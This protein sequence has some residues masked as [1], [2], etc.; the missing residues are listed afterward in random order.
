LRFLRP[1]GTTTCSTKPWENIA[2]AVQQIQIKPPRLPEEDSEEDDGVGPPRVYVLVAHSKRINTLLGKLWTGLRGGDVVRVTRNGTW[3]SLGKP[4]KYGKIP[5][6]STEHIQD[7]LP[8]GARLY[9]VTAKARGLYTGKDPPLDPTG[10]YADQKQAAKLIRDDLETVEGTVRLVYMASHLLRGHQAAVV[11]QDTLSGTGTF[12]NPSGWAALAKQLGVTY[13]LP[14]LHRQHDLE[15]LWKCLRAWRWSG[16]R[17]RVHCHV[18]AHNLQTMQNWFG[19]DVVSEGTIVCVEAGRYRFLGPTQATTQVTTQVDAILPEHN[20]VYL[21]AGLKKGDQRQHRMGRLRAGLR[22]RADILADYP[23]D[24]VDWRCHSVGG[25]NDWRSA[26]SGQKFNNGTIHVYFPIRESPVTSGTVHQQ[27]NVE[28]SPEEQEQVAKL[29][30][31]VSEV[32]ILRLCAKTKWDKLCEL[33]ELTT[34]KVAPNV[35]CCLVPTTVAWLER[36]FGP[37]DKGQA[38]IVR[39]RK[40]GWRWLQADSLPTQET[41]DVETE[42]DTGLPE[43]VRLYLV[44]TDMRPPAVSTEPNGVDWRRVDIHMWAGLRIRVD[45]T[46]ECAPGQ[47]QRVLASR[48]PPQWDYALGSESIAI[49]GEAPVVVGKSLGET[50]RGGAQISSPEMKAR[51]AGVFGA[52]ESS[53]FLHGIT[54]KGAQAGGLSVATY[55]QQNKNPSVPGFYMCNNEPRGLWRPTGRHAQFQRLCGNTHKFHDTGF[56]LATDQTVHHPTTPGW[57]CPLDG[58]DC[59]SGAGQSSSGIV[60][61]GTDS[62]GKVRRMPTPE[63]VAKKVGVSWGC[64]PKGR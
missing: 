54:L 25:L 8:D 51:L 32:N 59:T 2:Q 58:G 4:V 18:V 17:D 31:E 27:D 11:L 23:P 61:S 52:N 19:R 48:A 42:V 10:V 28:Y 15:S 29:C 53:L 55:C 13:Y 35:V 47:V 26:L 63:A 57:T 24:K 22:V 37:R 38:G 56:R 60:T 7:I 39:V 3:S 1:P 9:I 16:G 41:E 50:Y 36:T 34:P 20:R 40:G 49:Q 43:R 44:A 6:N 21:V 5:R 30:Q 64:R 46:E 33:F 14:A 62:T 45:I 12:C